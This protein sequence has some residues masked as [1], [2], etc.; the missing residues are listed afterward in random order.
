[1]RKPSILVCASCGATSGIC[2]YVGGSGTTG[3]FSAPEVHYRCMTQTGGVASK[4]R[5]WPAL[6]NDALGSKTQKNLRSLRI[7]LFII[8]YMTYG[9]TTHISGGNV[10]LKQRH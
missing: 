1:M 6:K 4:P 2:I 9:Q 3:S 5:S 7:C 10:S 8:I